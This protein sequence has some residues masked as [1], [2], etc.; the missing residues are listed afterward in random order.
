FRNIGQLYHDPVTGLQP[1]RQEPGSGRFRSR[2][3]FRVSPALV[4]ANDGHRVAALLRTRGQ[5]LTEGFSAPVAVRAI[6]LRELGR[7]DLLQRHHDGSFSLQLLC[8]TG[9]FSPAADSL[10]AQDAVLERPSSSTPSARRIACSLAEVSS[11]SSAG[12]EP[13][14]MP[15]PA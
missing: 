15:A 14:T 2:Q 11:A 8:E 12:T 4:S 7:P 10:E 9:V 6:S 5:H 3:Q 13:S 1:K